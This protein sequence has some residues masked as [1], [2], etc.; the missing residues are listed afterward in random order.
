MVTVKENLNSKWSHRRT[1][2]MSNTKTKKRQVIDFLA[3]GKGLTAA[4]AKSRFGVN[5]FRAC[6]SDIKEQVEGYHR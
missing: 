1:F 5:N 4:E 6:M 2:A 3:S